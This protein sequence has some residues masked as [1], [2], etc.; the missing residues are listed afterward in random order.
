[1]HIFQERDASHTFS[2]PIPSHRDS[3]ASLSHHTTFLTLPQLTHLH[4]SVIPIAPCVH[5]AYLFQLKKG[6]SQM[7]QHVTRRVHTIPRLHPCILAY[8]TSM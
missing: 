8:L 7:R 2:I 1:M 6:A 5:F 3:T 4:T